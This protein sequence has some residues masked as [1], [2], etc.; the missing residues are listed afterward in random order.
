MSDTTYITLSQLQAAVHDT[1]TQ[2]FAQP[3]WV[4][5]EIADLKVNASGHCYIELVEK[6]GANGVPL[7]QAR[8]V[9][10]Q[11]AYVQISSRFEAE[12]GE[13]LQSGIKVLVRLKVTYHQLYGLALQI[14]DIDPAYT[15]GDMARQRQATIEQLQKDG[16]WDMN[17]ELALP[18][19]VQRIA[20]ISSA[21]A[22][23]YQDFMNELGK[24]PYSFSTTLFDAVM[25]GTAA[26]E[27]IIEALCTIHDSAEEF[28]VAIIIRG[29]GSTTDLKCF[30]SYRLSSYVAQ[31]PL[32]IL[33]GIGHDKDTSVVDMVAHTQLKTPTA[34]ATWLVEQMQSVDAWLGNAALMLHDYVVKTMHSHALNLERKTSELHRAAQQLLDHNKFRLDT[35]ADTLPQLA[36]TFIAGQMT[37][38]SSYAE[39]VESHSPERVLR[40]GYAIVRHNKQA[41]KSVGDVKRGD[42]LQITL[43]DGKITTKVE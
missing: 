8:A 19:V 30:D 21:N 25:Q 42:R 16:V 40:L 17:R 4:T 1:L 43:T 18:K 39:I 10:W 35:I 31:F 38:L 37:Q 7:A 26:E 6:G 28:D 41:L 22:A 24:S 11:S 33:T 36:D 20:I 2:R 23:G 14:V 3:L 15:L 27:S 12:A 5:A 13:R 34:V 9:V 32:P 29:G